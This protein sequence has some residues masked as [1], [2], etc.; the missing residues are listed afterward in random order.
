M[1]HG[2]ERE[3]KFDVPEDFELPALEAVANESTVT[4][5]A[6]YW[7]TPDLRL[8]RWGHTL[9][10][11]HAADGSED[12]WTLKL[13]APR[14]RSSSRSDHVLDR[15]EISVGG[16]SAIPPREVRSLVTGL[17]R[18][19]RLGPIARIETT[20]H[21]LL[22]EGHRDGT[23]T[24]EL[25]DDTTAST[26]EGEPR[27]SFRQIEV[28]ALGPSS[29][30]I[31]HGV[32][33]RLTEAGAI[34]TRSTKLQLALGTASKP[35]VRAKRLRRDATVSELARSAIA[36][37]TI[38]LMQQDPRGAARSDPEA[39][40]QARVATR[41][42]RSDLKTLEPLLSPA[43]VLRF[44][45][46]LA[47]FGDLLGAVRDLDV[48]ALRIEDHARRVPRV[49]DEARDALISVCHDDRRVR[50]LELVEAMG[51][52]RYINL[53]EALV[54]ASHHPPVLKRFSGRR[55]SR[56]FRKLVRKTW[57]R[58]ARAVRHLDRAPSNESLH[59]VRKRAKRARYAAE[60]GR[61][62]FGKPA[63]RLAKRLEKVQDTLG[64]LQDAV[65]AEEYLASLPARGV[66]ASAA[67]VAGAI[68]CE[69]RGACA[70]VRTRWRADWKAATIG[71]SADGS[72]DLPPGAKRPPSMTQGSASPGGGEFAFVERHAA[73][74]LD[75]VESGALLPT[76]V[77]ALVEGGTE[78]VAPR[79]PSEVAQDRRDGGRPTSRSGAPGSW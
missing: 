8:L 48:M 10:Y 76:A 39:V 22:I 67:Y 60:L 29:S 58:T 78:A 31:L 34:P 77:L 65:V 26:V 38:R 44:R 73:D 14:R 74:A 9:R 41:R 64:E 57:R 54:S 28:E 61:G 24:V 23:D 75:T 6:T 17:I 27:P 2:R 3:M 40:H 49:N 47:W 35:E 16:L 43:A 32:T 21:S 7:D 11:R 59:E 68:A 36:S 66:S 30:S 69:E 53:L 15:T 46:D 45:E 72:D 56:R 70:S 50:W 63:R 1:K 5:L 4:L 51:S 55:A 19:A 20:R 13:S 71:G 25:S 62:L 12:G 37:G 33:G 42:L 18:R 52:P 79:G